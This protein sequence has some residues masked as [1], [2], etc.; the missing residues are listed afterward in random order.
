MPSCAEP[1]VPADLFSQE[2]TNRRAQQGADVDPHVEN[3]E[4]GVASGAPLWIEIGDNGADIRLEQT[5]AE[6]D[7]GQAQVERGEPGHRQRVMT[8]R[9]DHAA[10]EHGPALPDQAVGDPPP[11]QSQHV[12]GERVQPVD[13]SRR[14]DRHAEAAVGHLHL[15]DHEEHE[16][17]A[18]AV[19]AEALPHLGEKQRRQAARMSKPLRVWGY[20]RV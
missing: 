8:G 17:R 5:R 1:Q 10:D 6:N 12:D 13:R 15:L 14:G 16:Q 9:D 19:V 20:V 4:T 7:Q 2:R 18:H 3:R 11:W